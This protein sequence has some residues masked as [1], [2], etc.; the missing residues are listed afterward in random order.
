MEIV[1]HDCRDMEWR[2]KA[3]E[4]IVGAGKAKW[5]KS[6]QYGEVSKVKTYSSHTK[7][8]SFLVCLAFSSFHSMSCVD[9]ACCFLSAVSEYHSCGVGGRSDSP[10][11]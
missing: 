3:E 6:V 9:A 4:F 10:H 2:Q 7:N 1:K 8:S 11:W 5:W